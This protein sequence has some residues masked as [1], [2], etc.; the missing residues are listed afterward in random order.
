MHNAVVYKDDIFLI[1]KSYLCKLSLENDNIFLKQCT[2]IQGLTK[3]DSTFKL[4]KVFDKLFI[5]NETE[6]FQYVED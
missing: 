6:S 1:V 4:V 5:S 2:K 3:K